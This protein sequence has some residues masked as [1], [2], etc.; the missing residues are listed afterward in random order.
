MAQGKRS[1]NVSGI[2]PEFESSGI[3]IVLDEWN[4]TYQS[5]KVSFVN[6]F[7]K[8]ATLNLELFTFKSL[9]KAR[10]KTQ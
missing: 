8:C 9:D 4:S 5:I 1:H 6:S 7:Q 2:Q 3:I 10:K